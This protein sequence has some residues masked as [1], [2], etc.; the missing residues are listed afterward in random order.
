MNNAIKI[1]GTIMKCKKRITLGVLVLGLAL[2]Q[3]PAYA[4]FGNASDC[5]IP[6]GDW[7][8][9]GGGHH[10]GD[11]H[12][13]GNGSDCNIPGDHGHP[14]TG[15]D[16]HGG[17]QHAD[18]GHGGHGGGQQGGG[19]GSDCNVPGGGNGQPGHGQPGGGNGSDCN[20]PG[21]NG[22]PGGDQYAGGGHHGGGNASDNNKPGCDPGGNASDHNKPGGND[23]AHNKPGHGGHGNASD[24]NKPACDIPGSGIASDDKAS[25]GIQADKGRSDS[26]TKIVGKEKDENVP[27]DSKQD[28]NNLE[29]RK[30]SVKPEEGSAQI[31]D[32]PLKNADLFGAVMLESH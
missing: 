7:G 22:H 18:G 6:G 17:G 2:V 14:G 20:V 21:G 4:N 16:H 15:G 25:G 3:N 9:H 11:W 31:Q 13:G 26:G 30:H 29:D 24:N 23:W 1:G 8:H 32:L 19:N 5:N 12:H 27:V 10:G 28:L